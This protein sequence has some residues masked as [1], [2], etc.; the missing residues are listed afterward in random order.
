MNNTQETKQKNSGKPGRPTN[1]AKRYRNVGRKLFD[2]KDEKVVVKKLEEAFAIGTSDKEACFYA[3]ISTG[4][5]YDYQKKNPDFLKRKK[6]LKQ[7]PVLKARRTLFNDLDKP[8][9]AKWFLERKR[10]KEFGPKTT[11]DMNVKEKEKLDEHRDELKE[12]INN[13]KTKTTTTK[14]DDKTGEPPSV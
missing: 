10:R 14:P 5:L 6:E 7:K 4:A 8:E 13:A 11:I 12:L 2:G 9:T 1:H 3:G